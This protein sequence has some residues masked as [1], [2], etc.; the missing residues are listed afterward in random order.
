MGKQYKFEELDD[1]GFEFGIEIEED[2][3]QVGEEKKEVYKFD[4]MNNRPDLLTEA[5]LTRIFKIYLSQ[6]ETP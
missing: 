1:F 3:E 5:S 6:I 2:V 4:C